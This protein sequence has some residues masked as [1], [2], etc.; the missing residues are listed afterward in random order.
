VANAPLAS[1]S[2]WAAALKAGDFTGE[3][4]LLCADGS[5]AAV[6]WAA[7]T[8]IVTGRRLVLFVAVAAWSCSWR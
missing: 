5:S 1:P 6:Q 2:Q 8:E 3:A 7:T 4:D